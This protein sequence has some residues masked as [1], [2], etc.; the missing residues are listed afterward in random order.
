MLFA[1]RLRVAVAMHDPTNAKNSRW[2]LE[3][4]FEGVDFP[5]T[6]YSSPPCCSLAVHPRPHS[7]LTMH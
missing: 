4:L 6:R 5:Y 1:Y 2:H 7:T 3:R